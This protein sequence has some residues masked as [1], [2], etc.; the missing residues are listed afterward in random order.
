MTS[1]SQGNLEE[2]SVV[3]R[4]VCLAYSRM[5]NGRCVAGRELRADGRLGAWIRP[6][7]GGEDEG[8][9]E[10]VSRYANGS[11]PRLLDVMDVP[12]TSRPVRRATSERTGCS[13]RAKGGA[14]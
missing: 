2:S 1:D 13:I 10:E 11:L 3:K 5:P 14:E 12:V 6:V 9:T 8:V 7:T 4:M